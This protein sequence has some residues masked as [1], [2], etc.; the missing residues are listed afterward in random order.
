MTSDSHATSI[1][2][3]E[4]SLRDPSLVISDAFIDGEW[5]QRDNTFPVYEPSTGKILS[6]VANVTKADFIDAINSAT[7][8]QAQFYE[9]TTGPQRGQI[10]RAWYDRIQKNIDDCTWQ[11]ANIRGDL[12][13]S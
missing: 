5:V 7:P 9:S 6:S 13:Q 4:S 11:T 1:A 10:L 3:W 2:G 8:A 12:V